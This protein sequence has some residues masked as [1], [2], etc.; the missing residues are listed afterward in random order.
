[1]VRLARPSLFVLEPA[2]EVG[3]HELSGFF[4]R[5]TRAPIPQAQIVGSVLA[6]P[7]TTL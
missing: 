3:T 6:Y 5:Q 1:M 4:F 7:P 2:G